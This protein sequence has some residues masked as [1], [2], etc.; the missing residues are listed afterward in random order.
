MG[1]L[2]PAEVTILPQC[3]RLPTFRVRSFSGNLLHLLYIHVS[4]CALSIH[5]KPIVHS[6][7]LT[8]GGGVWTWSYNM[9]EKLAPVLTAPWCKQA[10]LLLLPLDWL[11]SPLRW[12]IQN[13]CKC[14]IPSVPFGTDDSDDTQTS[15]QGNQSMCRYPVSGSQD[16]RP[17]DSRGI[18]QL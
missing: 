15:P 1:K 14:S 16:C 5:W 2:L 8:W 6:H 17:R 4:K 13:K 3:P 11:F 10:C 9:S 18:A 12:T 7:F